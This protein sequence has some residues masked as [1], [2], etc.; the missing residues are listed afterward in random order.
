MISLSNILCVIIPTAKESTKDN[1]NH[2]KQNMITP[3]MTRMDTNNIMQFV[4]SICS[5]GIK[6]AI[7]ITATTVSLGSK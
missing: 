4:K 1:C 6:L 2:S 7:I 3:I 5:F